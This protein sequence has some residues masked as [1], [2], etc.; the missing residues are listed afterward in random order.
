MKN[1]KYL[2]N[3]DPE[4]FAEINIEKTLEENPGII[5]DEI[6]IGLRKRIWFTCHKC[7]QT[8]YQNI[9]ERFSHNFGCPYCKGHLAIPG[10]TDIISWC[11]ENN[12]QD[13]MEELYRNSHNKDIDFSRVSAHS[14]KKFYF[15]C[16]HGHEYQQQLYNKVNRNEKCPECNKI[17]I[18]KPGFDVYS[19]CKNNNLD[20]ILEDYYRFH[21]NI[22]DLKNISIGSHRLLTFECSEGHVYKQIIKSKIYSNYGCPDCHRKSSIPQ[23]LIYEICKEKYQNTELE[24][25]IN[26]W[27]IDIFIPELLYCIEYDGIRYH[28]SDAAKNREFRKNFAILSDKQ[29]KYKLFRIKETFDASKLSKFHEIIDGVEIYYISNTYTKKYF[30]RLQKIIDDIIKYNVKNIKKLFYNIKEKYKK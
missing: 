6:S 12:R 15:T 9:K 24:P 8:Y 7:G 18:P 17:K 16:E 29:H 22:D 13:I 30:D 4:L 23:L 26:K 1:R 11:K 27:E 10:K 28:N 3:I 14:S 19:Y 20:S 25:K 2:K 21:H 5:I